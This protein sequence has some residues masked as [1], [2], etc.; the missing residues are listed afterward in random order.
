VSEY[1]RQYPQKAVVYSA[2]KY[3]EMGWA[4]LMAG[5]SC[6]AIPI[7]DD[8]LLRSIASMKPVKS[9]GCSKQSGDSSTESGRGSYMLA[10]E[11]GWLVYHD[12]NDAQSSIELGKSRYTLWR[13]DPIAG[14]LAKQKTVKG[15]V[16]LNGKGIFWITQG[17]R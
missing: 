2:Q 16:V 17:R 9:D 7:V 1:R 10:G 8:D 6:A 12:S 5:G 14:R 3:P 11:Q 15:T 4:A 13:V